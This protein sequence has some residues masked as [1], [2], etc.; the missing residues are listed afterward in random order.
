MGGATAR[1]VP[2]SGGCECP[3]AAPPAPLP[4]GSLWFS[5]RPGGGWDEAAGARASPQALKAP[6]RGSPR[7]APGAGSG[8]AG[9]GGRRR[10][11]DLAAARATASPVSKDNEHWQ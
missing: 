6:G 4:A 10:V 1:A 11:L 5:A 9:S 3:G 7:N 2:P 8:A